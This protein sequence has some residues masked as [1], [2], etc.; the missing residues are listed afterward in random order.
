MRRGNQGRIVLLRDHG[1]RVLRRSNRSHCGGSS[2]KV[3]VVN[4]KSRFQKTVPKL[5]PMRVIPNIVVVCRSLRIGAVVN[6]ARRRRRQH[7]RIHVWTR[8]CTC[9]RRGKR[10][11]LILG[12]I[13]A[14]PA[15]V[16]GA[17][18]TT[19]SARVRVVCHGVIFR[20]EG[21]LG[22]FAGSLLHR[23]QL[24]LWGG[25]WWF[26]CL[27]KGSSSPI[28]VSFF[29]VNAFFVVIERA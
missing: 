5:V 19:L 13:R 8:H 26:Q 7:K 15:V 6:Q 10:R 25:L 21:E 2:L 1:R 9:L 17:G 11:P 24:F 16:R 14:S 22:E 23:T 20:Y 29:F 27:S 18:V 28:G 4:V 12:L 3:V